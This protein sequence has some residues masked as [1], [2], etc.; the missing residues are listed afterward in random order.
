M[1]S[2]T[3]KKKW[4]NCRTKLRRM[5]VDINRIPCPENLDHPYPIIY[6]I[7]NNQY[8]N[9]FQSFSGNL[10]NCCLVGF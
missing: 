4:K 2:K 3:P 5:I 10:L 6:L 8:I 9:I 1:T 7:F